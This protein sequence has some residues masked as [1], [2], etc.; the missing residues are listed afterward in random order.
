MTP[1][2]TNQKMKTQVY[3]DD[4]GRESVV[5]LKVMNL[6]IPEIEFDQIIYIFGVSSFH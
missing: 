2:Q 5:K 6:R 4:R 3:C 1:I